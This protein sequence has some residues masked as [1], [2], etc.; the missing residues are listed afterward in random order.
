MKLGTGRSA[1]EEGGMGDSSKWKVAKGVGT[2]PWLWV[3]SHNQ[4]FPLVSWNLGFSFSSLI[5]ALPEELLS[6]YWNGELGLGHTWVGLN[7]QL[8]GKFST[9]IALTVCSLPWIKAH[10]AG[11]QADTCLL[12][13]SPQHHLLQGQVSKSVIM[14]PS[15]GGLKA[16]EV[17]PNSVIQTWPH[18]EMSPSQNSPN[19]LWH[20][21]FSRGYRDFQAVS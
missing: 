21:N 19:Q 15:W 5:L 17:S 18:T 13:S 1:E 14:T 8:K 7:G 11:R 9:V 6:L 16:Y 20:R 2:I 12:F 10:R 4:D 3:R